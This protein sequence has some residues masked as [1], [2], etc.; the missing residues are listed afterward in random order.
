MKKIELL[1]PVGGYEQF[2]AAVESGADAVYLGGSMFN[3]RNSAANFSDDELK[4]AVKYAHVRGVKVHLT[5]NILI[6]DKEIDEAID[7][8]KRAYSYG[9]DAFI[10]QDLGLVKLIKD[11]IPD[12]N[13]HFST[14]GTV[15]S[16]EGVNAVKP[17]NFERVVLSRELTLD[18]IEEICSNTD[19]EIEVFVHGA[20]CICYSGQCRFSSLVGERS[21]NRGKCAQPCRLKYSLCENDKVRRSE[22]ILSPKDLCGIHDLVRLIK[23]GVSSLKIEGRLKS[24][25]YVAC[26]TSIYRKYIDFAYELI[27]NGEEE[28]FKVSEEDIKKLA[29]VFNRGG[30]SRGYYY[31]ESSRELMCYERPKH[32]GIYLGKVI[33][34]DRRRKLV[35]LKLDDTL[36]M[37]DGVEI[38]N[39]SLPGNIVTYI[40]KDKKQI[41][42][43]NRGD[44][45]LIG[46]ITGDIKSGD[47][48]YKI[49][50]KLLNNELKF[51]TNGKF[52][53]KVSIDMHLYAKVNENVILTISDEFN[54]SISYKSEYVAEKALNR[55]LNLDNA[56]AALSKLG[57]TPFLL[58]KLSLEIGEDV[59]V[60]MSVLNEIRREAVKLFEIKLEGIDKAISDK[61]VTD[62]CICD[63]KIEGKV[64][65]YL[66][67]TENLDG[68]ELADRIYVP[69]DKYTKEIQDKF[70]GKEVIPYLNTI[71]KN[72]KYNIEGIDS[73]LLGNLEHLDIFK[74]VENK[75]CDFSFNIFNSYSLEVLKDIYHIK[76]VNLSFELNLDE[77]KQIK[78]DIETEITVYG[79]LPL[80]ISEHCTIGSEMVGKNNCNMCEKSQFFLKDRKDEMFPIITDRENCRMQIL[81]S[82]I[83][84]SSEVV[85]ELKGKVD[86][87]R[88]YFFDE[89]T[90]ERRKVIKAVKNGEKVSSNKYTSGHFYR[91]V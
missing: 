6:H 42:A 15:Y 49:S 22:Y 73:I 78:S 5:L 47:K 40:E 76:G 29:Q 81:N 61:K 4:K 90:E 25:E 36:N 70:S 69:I 13:I 35:K 53:R 12:I 85:K 89:S 64:S 63:R 83:L 62:I 7:F 66:Y 20:L 71:T 23:I 38:V 39:S 32:W 50:D 82:K 87:F 16:L 51:F 74:N 24:P 75:Y 34:Y 9:V 27:E 17:F 60:P 68:L 37:G 18:E 45:V 21:G 46:D 56:R 54:N 26:V 80:M 58:D 30:F 41:K 1:A 52:Y 88:V 31:G 67:N 59:L 19:T 91:G 86:Y 8:A 77:I 28:K 79:R 3:A 11:V 10:V 84:F 55:A 14:Q 72:N 33:E 44:A 2:I 65:V 43:A 48:V 57:D